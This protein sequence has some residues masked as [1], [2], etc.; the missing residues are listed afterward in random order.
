MAS[1][2]LKEIC[3][4]LGAEVHAPGDADVLV[5]RVAVCDVLSFVLGTDTC[6][7]AWVTV[8]THLNV[9]AVA[10]QKG[11]PMVILASGRAPADDLAARCRA[12]NIALVTSRASMFETCLALGRLGLT[13]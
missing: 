2:K 7:A 3:S 8:Q 13:G 6:G 10:A 11:I 12:E 5:D 1:K 9:A 4:A